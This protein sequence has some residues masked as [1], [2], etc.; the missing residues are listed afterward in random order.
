MQKD[1]EQQQS[2]KIVIPYKP[3]LQFKT[4]HERKQRWA[5][6]V[7]HR[8]FGKTVGCINDDI[9]DCLKSSH[10]E[11]GAPLK[12]FRAAYIAP[13]YKQAKAVAWDYAKRYS[14]VVPGVEFNESELRIDFPNG[15]RYRLFGADNYDAMRGIYLDKVTLDE[16]ADMDPRAWAEVIRPALADRRGRGTFIGTPKGKNGFWEI[17]DRA[18]TDPAWFT[19]LLR[20]RDTGIL[21]PE[22]LA[23]AAKTM[24]PDQFQQEF[25]CSFDAA[26]VGA[27]YGKEM[28]EAEEQGRVTSV[29]HDPG[30]LTYT[31]WDIGID[32]ATAIWFVQVVG[33]EFRVI[34]YYESSDV[35]VAHYADLVRSKPYRYET[36]YL[37]HDA[38]KRDQ[39]SAVTYQDQLET[40]LGARVEV[41]K[42]DSLIDGIEAVR[43]LIPQ[44]TFD[45]TKCGRGVEALKQYRREFDD[46][47]KAYR[48]KP[49]HDWS[50]HGADAFR[51][52]AMNHRFKNTN[53]DLIR[54]LN[55]GGARASSYM[56]M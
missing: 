46:K 3:R 49:L 14:G 7:A 22:E 12:E 54:K 20:S 53:T 43:R 11:T 4:Y 33:R 39:G 37:P 9:R 35:P 50:S 32:D 15:A 40:S 6:I 19:L 31:A 56:G 10:W 38:H 28:R 16:P 45:K 29:P 8:R 30:A 41:C 5:C 25:E 2:A 1:K 55:A 52:F 47:L 34:D 26:I 13:L 21:G 44:A 42:Q 36:H 48:Q 18:K 51:T 24:S 23:D 17:Y 27:Y